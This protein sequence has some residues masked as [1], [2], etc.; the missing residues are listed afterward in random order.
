M[1]GLEAQS[2]ICSASVPKARTPG[3]TDRAREGVAMDAG[4]K[5]GPRFTFPG[6]LLEGMWS[7]GKAI[8]I[9]PEEAPLVK[10]LGHD[11]LY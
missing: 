2:T 3:L 11:V 7:C 5:F 8:T 9:P 4:G 6:L 10:I 1:A